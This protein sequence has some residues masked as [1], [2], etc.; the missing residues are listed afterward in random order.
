MKVAAIHYL[1]EKIASTKNSTSFSTISSFQKPE[2]GG[3]LHASV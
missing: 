2:I 3:V 1:E